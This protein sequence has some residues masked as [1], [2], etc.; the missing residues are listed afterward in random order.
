[1]IVMRGQQ[2]DIEASSLASLMVERF[3]EFGDSIAVVSEHV[4]YSFLQT[5]DMSLN[6]AMTIH[7]KG[8]KDD[9][10][11]V[12]QDNRSL[13]SLVA[14]IACVL[15]GHTC[16][17]LATN[18]RLAPDE[19]IEEEPICNLAIGAILTPK[20]T[21]FETYISTPE[22]IGGSLWKQHLIEKIK[23]VRA[24]SSANP[25]PT[26]YV[27][28]GTTGSTKAVLQSEIAILNEILWTQEY[29]DLSK[30]TR[31]MWGRSPMFAVSRWEIWSFLLSGCQLH[32]L[33][34]DIEGSPK[35][36]AEWMTSQEI[37]IAFI[38]PGVVHA[39][40]QNMWE[41]NRSLR[42][43]ISGGDIL[44]ARP[45]VPS[46]CRVFNSYG[47]SEVSSVRTIFEVPSNYSSGQPIPIGYPIFNTEVYLIQDSTDLCQVDGEGE[48]YIG[49]VGLDQGYLGHEGEQK[50]RFLTKSFAGDKIV[51]K[52]GDLGKLNRQDN[53]LLFVGRIGVNFISRI[54]EIEGA[55]RRSLEEIEQAIITITNV[56]N[57]C[58]V[59]FDNAQGAPIIVAW[60]QGNKEDF[61]EEDVRAK[62]RTLIPSCF[63]PDRFHF[64]SNLPMTTNG[65]LDRERI[66]KWD[67]SI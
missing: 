4:E 14:Q 3:I 35:K 10:L 26:V 2:K 15:T 20:N 42:C 13:F 27:T 11:V 31:A 65:K 50:E 6:L 1:M 59:E 7:E 32:I 48:L 58:V 43:V 66:K 57:A 37:E 23:H 44:R 18:D 29:F 45:A 36:T 67:A 8:I 25:C 47:I 63:V 62:M 21:N 33:P 5:L 53:S 60:L 40:T 30:R 39:F 38:P 64:C 41:G 54:D 55:R 52:T 56:R 17:P 49:G 22:T 24:G 46:S 9:Q 19:R 34:L 28:S 12:V 51:Y 16:L 61:S